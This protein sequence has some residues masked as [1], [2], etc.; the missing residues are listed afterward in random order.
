MTR[1]FE[2][3]AVAEVRAKTGAS[4]NSRVDLGLA[5]VGVAKGDV[6]ALL[7]DGSDKF[8]TAWPLGSEGDE[9]KAAVSR[10]LESLVICEGGC[11]HGSRRM[12]PAVAGG[13]TEPGS[14]EVIT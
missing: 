14:F 13:G 2:R 4:A 7:C 9:A 10:S 11:P 5:R 6:H 8:S 1:Q 3:A 12:G